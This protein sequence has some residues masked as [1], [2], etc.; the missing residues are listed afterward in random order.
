MEL[1]NTDRRIVSMLQLDGRRSYTSIAQ[2]LDVSEGAVRYRAQR[3]INSGI[4]QIVAV[5]DPLQVGYE[6]LTMIDVVV[7]PGMAEEVAQRLADVDDVNWV[8]LLG[9]GRARVRVEVISQDVDHLREVLLNKIERVDGVLETKS[10]S[11]LKILK[12]N[13]GWGV[14]ESPVA[15]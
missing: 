3:L 9:S 15:D 13:H 6:L 12:T 1:D 5:T 10:E 2:E 11:I 7:E 8:C 4:M 14:P